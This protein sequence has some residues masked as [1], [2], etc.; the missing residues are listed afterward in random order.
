MVKVITF[1]R[2]L[3]RQMPDHMG[4][5]ASSSSALASRRCD[6]AIISFS[7]SALARI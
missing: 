6:R 7:R 2:Q 3:T 5:I 1:G 4:G